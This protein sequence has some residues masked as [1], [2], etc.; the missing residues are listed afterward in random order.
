VTCKCIAVSNQSF[1]MHCDN[2]AHAFS[3][4]ARAVAF[5]IFVGLLALLGAAA[6]AASLGKFVV[7][8]HIGEPF[9]GEIDLVKWNRHELDSFG[10]RLA[11]AES[12]RQAGLEYSPALEVLNFKL[13]NRPGAQPYIKVTSIQPLNEP[14]MDLV[15]D[16]ARSAGTSSY[17][18]TAL[19]DS[20]D[21]KVAHSFPGRV[22]A[23][24]VPL[25]AG[26][27]AKKAVQPRSKSAPSDKSGP[28]TKRQLAEQVRLK[29]EQAVVQKQKLAAARE[30]IAHLEQTAREQ[31]KRLAV[32]GAAAAPSGVQTAKAT[33]ARRDAPASGM[34]R[35]A[36]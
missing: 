19:I 35:I 7:M 18:Y 28:D 24:D 20:Q 10:A 12:Y 33:G 31:E 3:T 4:G 21:G 2:V 23:S 30:R 14:V 22:L 27:R 26:A 32:A 36:H 11:S 29:E 17:A 8:S 16:V 25:T 15:V 1:D 6:E 13:A 9:R 34:T 5:G